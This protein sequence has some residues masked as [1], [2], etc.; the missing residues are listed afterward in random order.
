M[1]EPSSI[2]SDRASALAHT[3]AAGLFPACELVDH[4]RVF[5][6]VHV[7]FALPR[8]IVNPFAIDDAALSSPKKYVTQTALVYSYGPHALELPAR[9]AGDLASFPW[10]AR[11]WMA[12]KGLDV[13]DEHLWAAWPHDY[14]CDHPEELPRAIGDA[15]FGHLLDELA[16]EKK[17]KRRQALEMFWAVRLYTRLK[18][19][20]SEG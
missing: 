18:Q 14:V 1:P 2:Y 15:I 11:L 3:V 10:L 7:Y 9:Y 13:V 19:W 8:G 17:L 6:R 5:G 12:W 4:V 16:A 20:V